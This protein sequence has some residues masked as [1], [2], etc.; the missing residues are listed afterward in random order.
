MRDLEKLLWPAAPLVLLGGMVGGLAL[1]ARQESPAPAQ[2]PP[3]EAPIPAVPIIRIVGAAKP[4]IPIAVPAFQGGADGKAQEL[5]K[6]THDTLRDDLDFSGYFSIVI[7][8]K[9]SS[10]EAV[11]HRKP[12]QIRHLLAELAFTRSPFSR[13]LAAWRSVCP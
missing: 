12:R 13:R 1:A 5:A 6:E 2:T 9:A 4:K 8:I 10:G 7:Q 3:P 11:F